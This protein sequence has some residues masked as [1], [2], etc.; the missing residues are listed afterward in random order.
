MRGTVLAVPASGSDGSSAW[1]KGFSAVQHTRVLVE[2][3][4]V[5]VSVSEN[6]RLR[7]RMGI[8]QIRKSPRPLK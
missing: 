6:Q 3:G 5:P 1:G 8:K 7:N 2:R 4:L